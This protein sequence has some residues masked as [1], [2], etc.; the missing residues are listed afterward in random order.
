MYRHWARRHE[1]KWTTAQRAWVRQ[2]P[3]DTRLTTFPLRPDSIV[4]DVGGY[5][6]D[7]VARIVEQYGSVVHVFEPVEA[8]CELIDQRFAG[9]DRVVCHRYG[10][11]SADERMR[12]SLAENRSSTV[13]SDGSGAEIA[14]RDILGVLAELGISHVDLAKINIEGGEYALI[15][16][17]IESGALSRFDRLLVQFHD[18]APGAKKRYAAISSALPKTHTLVFRYPFVWELWSRVG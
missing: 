7:W 14:I 10:L 17:L 5:H 3:T 12:I 4:L 15:E 2:N 6:G 13:V 16:R 11:G 9:D 18:F 8:F 1:W